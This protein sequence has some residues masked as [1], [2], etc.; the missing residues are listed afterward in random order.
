MCVCSLVVCV[1]VR[2]VYMHVATHF[3]VEYVRPDERYTCF[4]QGTAGTTSLTAHVKVFG[5]LGYD[6]AKTNTSGQTRMTK[7]RKI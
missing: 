4:V 5:K 6:L 1:C 3:Q 2:A 7:H